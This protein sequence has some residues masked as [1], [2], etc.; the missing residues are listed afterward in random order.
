MENL[1]HIV[2]KLP[3]NA[4]FCAMG[5]AAQQHKATIASLLLR[6]NVRM[7]F[8]DNIFFRKGELATSNVQ[9]VERIVVI[10]RDLG[11]EIATPDEARAIL[12]R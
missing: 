8:E 9:L 1:T 4:L 6:G 2:R 11:Y 5:I 10:A 12:G 7:G 3:P